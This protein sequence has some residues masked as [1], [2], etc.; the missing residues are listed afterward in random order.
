M[1]ENNLKSEVV[2]QLL[3][4][5]TFSQIKKLGSWIKIKNNRDKYKGYIKNN[6][7]LYTVNNTHKVSSLYACLY[8]KP[9]NKYKEPMSL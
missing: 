2:T 8:S 9:K 7:F 1:A 5:D 3:Y 4:G 6:T